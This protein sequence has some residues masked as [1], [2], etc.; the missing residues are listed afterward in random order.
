MRKI[1]AFFLLLFAVTATSGQPAPGTQKT[2]DLSPARWIWYP[3]GRILQNTF[4]LFRKEINLAEKPQ[5]ASGYILADSHYQLFVNGQRVQWGPAPADPRWSEADPLDLTPYLQ[6][7]KNV[8]ACQVL[9][10][11]MGEG[12]YAMGKPG[13]LF[14]LDVDGQRIVSDASWSSFLATSWKPGQYKRSFLRTL[15]EE[16]DARTFPYGWMEAEFV[17]DADWLP[18]EAP[19]G[20]ADKPSLCNGFPDYQF[21]IGPNRNIPEAYISPRSIPLLVENEVRVEKLTET[22]RI[23]WK[24]SPEEYFSILAP[25]AYTARS[26]D[27]ARETAPGVWTVQPQEGDGASL[28]FEFKEQSVGFPHFTIDAP[29]GTVIELLV[30]EGHAPGGPAIINSHFH[31]WSRFI[32]REGKNTFQTFDFESLRWLQ[33]HIRNFDRPVR[34]SEVGMLRRQFPWPHTPEIHI[35]ESALQRLMDASVNTLHNSAQDIVVDGMARERQQ[36]S[37]DGAHQLHPIYAAFGETRLPARFLRTFSQGITPEGYFLDCWPAFDRLTRLMSRT[38]QSTGWGP[39]LDHGVGFCF[40][41]FYYYQYTADAEPLKE[42]FPR[43]VRFFHYLQ[44]LRADSDLLPVENIGTPSVWIDHSAYKSQRNKQCAFNL[45]V[46]AAS[47]AALAPLA[48]VLGDQALADTMR[49][50]AEELEQAC[51]KKYWSPQHRTFINNLPWAAEDGELRYC[52]RSLATAIL[53]DQCPGG[54]TEESVRILAQRPPNLGISYPCN[55]VW[56]MW[57]Y[58][59]AGRIDCVLKEMREKWAT[60][61]S[62][63]EN[64]TLQESWI[65]T[66]D[67]REQWSHCAQAPLILLYQGIGGITPLSPGYE[68]IQIRPQ[69]GDLEEVSFIMQTPKGQIHFKSK[70]KKGKR[71][72]IL[73]IP[74]GCQAELILPPGEKI[75][76]P[77]SGTKYLLQGPDPVTLKLRQL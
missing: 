1:S 64:N 25:N 56:I 68:K 75:T 19:A 34:V 22:A 59:K 66:H 31:S 76:L 51:I 52:D 77:K 72:L 12:T 28:I 10:Y 63:I 55:A 16:F 23:T 15:Q 73:Q 6:P 67:S 35:S 14:N 8:I 50:F 60:M 7:G 47:K 39:I 4:V 49:R 11:G 3:S 20:K 48:E 5:K 44:A 58:A 65:A 17:P 30:H 29:E 45:Y 70:G 53:Y 21:D 62:V 37:G 46:A 40:D 9:Y 36:Y 71:E 43:L 33:L 13:L 61:T 38:V 18:A 74:A 32:C 41:N 69:P 24:R 54:D 57:A 27:L 26:V 2:L 42:T